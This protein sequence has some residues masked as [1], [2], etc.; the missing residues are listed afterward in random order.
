M[1]YPVTHHH[2]HITGR[3]KAAT[4]VRDFGRFEYERDIYAGHYARTAV[5]LRDEVLERLDGDLKPGDR[6]KIRNLRKHELSA[7]LAG[8]DT[9]RARDERA[10]RAAQANTTPEV[11]VSRK[12]RRQTPKPRKVIRTRAERAAAGTRKQRRDS[13][14]ARHNKNLP[15]NYHRTHALHAA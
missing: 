15:G 4:D 1:I 10:F 8:W 11:T 5:A 14:K 13:M 12:P 6:T 2:T 9:E 7:M 3:N